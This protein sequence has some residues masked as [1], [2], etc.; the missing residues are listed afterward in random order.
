MPGATGTAGG[1]PRTSRSDH[2]LRVIEPLPGLIGREGRRRILL[3]QQPLVMGGEK[4][5]HEAPHRLGVAGKVGLHQLECGVAAQGRVDTAP[6][7]RGALC[8]EWTYEQ[9]GV[10]DGDAKPGI[11]ETARRLS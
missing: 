10:A 5:L 6:L 9:V 8:F 11:V 7:R 1:D 4:D 3:R 2:R